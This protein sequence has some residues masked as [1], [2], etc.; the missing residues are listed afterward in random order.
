MIVNKKKRN[1]SRSKFLPFGTP[2]VRIN[3]LAINHGTEYNVVYI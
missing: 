1:I 3:A 2:K